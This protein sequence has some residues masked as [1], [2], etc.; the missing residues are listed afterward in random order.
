M[1]KNSRYSIMFGELIALD[2]KCRISAGRIGEL[3]SLKAQ[4]VFLVQIESNFNF[5]RSVI[6]LTRSPCYIVQ[7]CK[8]DVNT[9]LCFYRAKKD[10]GCEVNV[11]S[12]SHVANLLKARSFVL[13]CECTV[14]VLHL[15]LKSREGSQIVCVSISKSSGKKCDDKSRKRTKKQRIITPTV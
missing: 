14:C 7:S 8:Q 1:H 3:K 4:D 12:N 10:N 2:T 6:K 9:F 11:A 13:A 5:K 15:L